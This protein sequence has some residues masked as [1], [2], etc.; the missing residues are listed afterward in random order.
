MVDKCVMERWEREKMEGCVLW[1]EVELE[2]EAE[3][4]SL[5]RRVSRVLCSSLE[6]M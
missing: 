4:L 2:T 1:K 6:L 3:M 5:P